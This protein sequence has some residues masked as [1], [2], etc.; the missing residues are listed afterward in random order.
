MSP[1]KIEVE[2]LT[3]HF[4]DQVAVDSLSFSVEAGEVFGFLG[5]N[6]AGKTTTV[7]MLTGLLSPTSGEARIDG[8]PIGENPALRASIGVMSE[9][10]GLY[11][12][13]TVSENLAFFGE[14]QGLISAPDWT[15]TP[16]RGVGDWRCPKTQAPGGR[17]RLSSRTTSSGCSCWTQ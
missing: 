16:G 11:E 6:G 17:T 4:G 15:A 14:L 10:P 7:R 13:L 8:L 1:A 3:R 12:A 2:N 5:P 9:T